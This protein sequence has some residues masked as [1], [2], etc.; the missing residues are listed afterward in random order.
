MATVFLNGRYLLESDA[1][2]SINDRGFLYGDGIF[3][4]LRAY[5]GIP[6][7]LEDHYDRLFYSAEK[8]DLRIELNSGALKEIIIELLQRNGLKE[9]SVR[10]TVTRGKHSGDLSFISTS[11]STVLVVAKP[12]RDMEKEQKSGISAALVHGVG[13]PVELARHKIVSYLP[14]LYAREMARRAGCREA[15][16]VDNS[17]TILEAATGNVFIVIGGQVITPPLTAGILP[18]I[19][20]KTV[21]E[22]LTSIG[23]TAHEEPLAVKDLDKANE[24]FITNSIVEVLPINRVDKKSFAMADES[25]AR[26]ILR[27]YRSKVAEYIKRSNL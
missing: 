5:D 12:V 2:V 1:R 10:T 17:G 14:Y 18:G 22:L 27:A 9:A 8:L 19:A 21:L 11:P 24:I 16:L 3:D 15:I 13:N 6:F 7:C 23:L 25:I 20:R 4:T 26:R